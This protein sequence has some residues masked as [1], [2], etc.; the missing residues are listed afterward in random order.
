MASDEDAAR[1]HWQNFIYCKEARH[2]RNLWCRWKPD[3]SLSETFKAE[4]IFKPMMNGTACSNRIVYHYSDERGTV[5]EGP[6]CGPWTIS[7]AACSKSNGF[8]HPA[9]KEMT[10]LLLPGGG[11]SAWC[12]MDASEGQPCAAELFLYGRGLVPVS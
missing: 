8:I 3:G 10:T 7:E 12:W 9:R 11:D 4:R 1:K 6:L 5:K 2:W